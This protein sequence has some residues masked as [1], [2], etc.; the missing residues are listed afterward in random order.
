MEGRPLLAQ[1]TWTCGVGVALVMLADD[2]FGGVRQSMKTA[3]Q[4]VRGFTLPGQYNNA[5]DALMDEAARNVPVAASSAAIIRHGGTGNTERDDTLGP[6]PYLERAET[7]GRH[8]WSLSVT[9]QYLELNEL[10]GKKV[11]ADPYPVVLADGTVTPYSATPKPL[12]HLATVNFTY[13]V[14]DDLD[15]NLALPI[16]FNDFDYNVSNPDS[17]NPFKIVI[18][19]H[20]NTFNVGDL[21][22]RAKYRLGTWMG[23]IGAAGLDMRLPSGSTDKALGTG[24]VELGP[25]LAFSQLFAKRVELLYNAGFDFNANE[26]GL[27]SFVYGLGLNVRTCRWATLNA[28]F[29]GRS[30]VQG[31]ASFN[32]VSG[33]HQVNGATT[34][35]PYLGVGF[36]R[37]DYFDTNLGA[38]IKV[39]EHVALSLGVVKSLNDDGLRSSTW[40]PMGSVEA[41]F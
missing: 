26:V 5:V 29:L 13:G 10:N 27:S 11:G 4:R 41:Y 1:L 35:A 37:N 8:A 23:W 19:Q 20:N 21:H 6:L 36:D 38:R 32:Q 17:G 9:G 15:L 28:A 16:I 30:M 7:L 34:S 25:Y 22:L 33:P 39:G 24:D 2:A 40:G 31:R 3:P 14:L 18:P 12:Y